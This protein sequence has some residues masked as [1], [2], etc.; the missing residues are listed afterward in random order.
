MVVE[1]GSLVTLA[2]ALCLALASVVALDV[3]F[4]LQ[5]H[6]V[7]GAPS[8]TLRRPAGSALY[9]Y[10]NPPGA[11]R[12][13]TGTGCRARTEAVRVHEFLLDKV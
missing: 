8:L 7:S 13:A 1:G 9:P 4:L 3:G 2:L 12:Q 11:D 5:Q 10:T 6:A